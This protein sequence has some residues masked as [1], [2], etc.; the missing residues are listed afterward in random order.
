M[1]IFQTD[2]AYGKNIYRLNAMVELYLPVIPNTSII[3]EKGTPSIAA[4]D[5][6]LYYFNGTSWIEIASNDII[7]VSEITDMISYNGPAKIILV[8]DDLRG[9]IFI[10]SNTGVPDN[11]IVFPAVSGVWNRFLA[12]SNEVIADWWDDTFT[13]CIVSAVNYISSSGGIIK[14]SN[15]RYRYTGYDISNAMPY[16]NISII[17]EKMPYYNEN[18]TGLQ[19][20][21]IIDGTFAVHG[22]NFSMQN[23]GIDMGLNVA[24]AYSIE[25][26]GFCFSVPST[27]TYAPFTGLYINNLVTLCKSP[28]SLFHSA[29]FEGIEGAS[30]NNVTTCMG[31]HGIVIKGIDIQAIN[32]RSYN[33][34]DNGLILKSDLYAHYNKVQ[35]DSFIYDDRPPLTTPYEIVV[36][37]RGINLVAGNIMGST[38]IDKAITFNC[39]YGLNCSTTTDDSIGNFYIGEFLSDFTN[40]GIVLDIP[41]FK[42]IHIN[43]AN[44]TNSQNG[45]YMNSTE[46]MFPV[47]IESLFISNDTT[48]GITAISLNG[49]VQLKT[50]NLSIENYTTEFIS[51]G[52][53]QFNFQ[54]IN[55][56]GTKTGQDF[57]VYTNNT[58][59][60]IF[61]SNGDLEILNTANPT[62]L[63]NESGSA[64]KVSLYVNNGDVMCDEAGVAQRFIIKKTT[65][66]MGISNNSP[67]STLSVGG[68]FACK[69]RTTSSSGAILDTD[70][71]LLVNNIT[72]INLTLPAASSCIGRIY[73]IK[74]ISENSNT[75]TIGTSGGLID[76]E[77]TQILSTGYAF[78]IVISDGSNYY[79]TSSPL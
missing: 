58:K 7:S 13:S 59:R 53:A 42:R 14:L 17:G 21:T 20:G 16:D 24:T 18:C 55:S 62:L 29:L 41:T 78:I 39:I 51:S 60:A 27:S 45:I 36:G 44:I 11:G 75:V 38:S 64:T 68:S 63:L 79:L 65:G 48:P 2:P 23:V 10:L 52:V 61:H 69:T 54:N 50:N 8:E 26:D 35:I 22:N 57:N 5:N 33:H 74:K 67:L 73:I 25:G 32:L 30:I 6:K 34:Q 12:K 31:V 56:I 72:N 9:G 3:P 4:I 71:T 77:S 43:L 47:S 40:Y 28:T 15:K 49:G 76:G 19:G 70:F 1:G 37:T 66:Y 46:S